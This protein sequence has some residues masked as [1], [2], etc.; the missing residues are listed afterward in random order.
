MINAEAIQQAIALYQS[1]RKLD[2]LQAVEQLLSGISAHEKLAAELQVR[3]IDSAAQKSKR[4]GAEQVSDRTALINWLQLA[5]DR[6]FGRYAD[7]K[8]V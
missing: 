8:A 1:D 7:R 3:S 6:H 4:S 5:R 2:C